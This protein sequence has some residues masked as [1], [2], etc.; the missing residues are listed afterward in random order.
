M[1]ETYVL[2][3]ASAQF[4]INSPSSNPSPLKH[5]KST[6]KKQLLLSAPDKIVATKAIVAIV[7][8]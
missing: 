2:N 5:F 4:Y 7:R 1:I 6:V 8:F 3:R